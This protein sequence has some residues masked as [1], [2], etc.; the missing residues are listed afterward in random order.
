[1]SVDGIPSPRV[2][3]RNASP[4]DAPAARVTG[5]FGAE[6]QGL[7]SLSS[8]FHCGLVGLETGQDLLISG[9]PAYKFFRSAGH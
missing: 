1:M 5:Q 7:L 8:K 6:Q 4:A 2:T 9:S 3:V